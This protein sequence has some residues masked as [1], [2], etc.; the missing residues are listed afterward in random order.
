MTD[1]E[2]SYVQRLEA[3]LIDAT[4]DLEADAMALKVGI[5]SLA[6]RAAESPELAAIRLPVMVL[7]IFADGLDRNQSSA[8]IRREEL[9]E[10]GQALEGIRI[11]ERH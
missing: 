9:L 1:E 5:D 8:R 2:Q 6:K 11:M 7:R 10:E 3:L 4:T